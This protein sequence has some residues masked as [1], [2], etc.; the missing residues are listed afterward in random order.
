LKHEDAIPFIR[1]EDLELS[2]EDIHQATDGYVLVK[3]LD[4]PL[5]CSFLRGRTLRNMIPKDRSVGLK[6]I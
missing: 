1:G 3:Y 6:L 5:G 4:F 2:A